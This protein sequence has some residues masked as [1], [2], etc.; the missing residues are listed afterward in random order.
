MADFVVPSQRLRLVQYLLGERDVEEN[1][2][3]ITQQLSNRKNITARKRRYWFRPLLL[4]RPVLGQCESLMSELSNED[5]QA[6]KN[7]VRVEP[8]MFH[9]L[10]R[11]NSS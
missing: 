6:Y 9:E 5:V 10:L 8:A 3:A 4:R 1:D 2:V 7:F 11:T